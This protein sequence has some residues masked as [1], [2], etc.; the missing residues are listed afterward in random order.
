MRE[1]RAPGLGTVLALVL[2]LAWPVGSAQ[3]AIGSRELKLHA[4]V[5]EA[6]SVQGLWA[7]SLRAR[8]S[9]IAERHTRRMV[10]RGALFHSDLGKRLPGASAAEVVGYGTS[11]DA[12]FMDLLASGTHRDIL[13]GTA[14][15][16]TGVGVVR[17]GGLVWVT[18]IVRD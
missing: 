4:L 9:R 15:L 18:Q 1:A 10:D 2:V 17:H 6:R 16:K 8:L 5:N 12:V 13:L 3:A 14:W 7:L 11:V